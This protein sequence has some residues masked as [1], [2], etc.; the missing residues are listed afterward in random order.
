M[1]MTT[2][3]IFVTL[4][5]LLGGGDWAYCRW[6]AWKIAPRPHPMQVHAR[7]RRFTM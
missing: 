6:H 7:H 5:L 1:D 2:L 4:V 3:L